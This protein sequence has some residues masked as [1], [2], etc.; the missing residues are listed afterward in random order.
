MPVRD[1]LVVTPVPMAE[2]VEL[3]A[4]TGDDGELLAGVDVRVLEEDG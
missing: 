4:V 1:S 2:D 3:E